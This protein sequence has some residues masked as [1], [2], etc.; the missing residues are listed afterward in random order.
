MTCSFCGASG[1][2]IRLFDAISPKGIVK[3]CELCSRKEDIPILRRPTTFQ[4]KEAERKSEVY[5]ILSSAREYRESLKKIQDKEAEK[6]NTNLLL[7][8]IADKNYERFVSSEQKPRLDLVENFQW[9]IMRAR[10]FRK[11]TTEQLAREISES[12]AAIKM[13]E[14]GILPEDDY[15]IINKLGSFL[16]ITLVKNPEL[17]PPEISEKQPARILKFDPIM[18]KNI[19]ISDLKRM[20]EEK[21]FEKF[22]TENFEDFEDLDGDFEKNLK[23]NLEEEESR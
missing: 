19:T 7:K 10:K 11:L 2:K 15:R 16:G 17:Q 22:K 6:Q 3:I 4:L 9:V 21:D 8:Q 20:K 12:E 13:A 23:E 14:K 5:K 1:Q 18:A